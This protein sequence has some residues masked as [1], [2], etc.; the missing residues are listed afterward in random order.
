MKKK[1][2]QDTNYFCELT[3]KVEKQNKLSDE[4]LNII[5]NVEDY[6]RSELQGIIEAR[7]CRNC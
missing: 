7:V 5:D 6:T 1:S 2:I 4:L 3:A